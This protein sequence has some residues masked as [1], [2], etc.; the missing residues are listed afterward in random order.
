MLIKK[1]SRNTS[2]YNTKPNREE[3]PKILD[4]I[5]EGFFIPNLS[6]YSVASDEVDFRDAVVHKTQS[7]RASN[8]SPV[9]VCPN[10]SWEVGLPLAPS[11]RRELHIRTPAHPDHVS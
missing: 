3:G 4:V 11:I 9:A 1:D 7:Q 6:W 5:I 10:F 2:S 8:D